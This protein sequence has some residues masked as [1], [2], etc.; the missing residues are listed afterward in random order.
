ME[1]KQTLPVPHDTYT[2]PLNLVVCSRYL[3]LPY[4]T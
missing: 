2:Y 1:V 4:L 3:I